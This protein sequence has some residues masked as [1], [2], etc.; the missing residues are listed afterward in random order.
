VL[1]EEVATLVNEYLQAGVL[2]QAAFNATKL[3]SGLYFYRLQSG[4][5][6]QVKKSVLIK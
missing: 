3:S 1:G 6:T 4:K 5:Q 2:H